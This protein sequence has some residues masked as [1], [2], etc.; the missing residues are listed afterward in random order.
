MGIDAPGFSIA[1]MRVPGDVCATD[2]GDGKLEKPSVPYCGNTLVLD[3]DKYPGTFVGI[4]TDGVDGALKDI[5]V[6]A[7]DC[8]TIGLNGDDV[9]LT[10]NV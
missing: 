4:G 6:G 10:P 7:G 2:D 8:K 1:G 3:T 9:L 5:G